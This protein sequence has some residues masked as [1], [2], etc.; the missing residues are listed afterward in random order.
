MQRCREREEG[1]PRSH[2]RQTPRYKRYGIQR[3]QTSRHIIKAHSHE[4]GDYKRPYA[5]NLG[6][7][8]LCPNPPPP[9]QI[10]SS[11]RQIALTSS[12]TR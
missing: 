10:I 4:A 7:T 9:H 11:D 1:M 3:L 5:A 12:S 8:N 6:P 2:S